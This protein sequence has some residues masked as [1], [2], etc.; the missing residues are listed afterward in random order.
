MCGGLARKEE[1]FVI[2]HLT[3]FSW[4]FEEGLGPALPLCLC[5]LRVSVLKSRL[6][7]N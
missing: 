5:V 2:G 6:A 4:H 7:F 1:S 3:F